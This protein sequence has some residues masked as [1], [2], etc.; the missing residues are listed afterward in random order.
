MDLEFVVP[1]G[2]GVRKGALDK[3]EKWSLLEG[4]NI[5]PA[6]KCLKCWNKKCWRRNGIEGKERKKGKLSKYEDY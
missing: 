6:I 3:K 1:V 5:I 2:H 4:E